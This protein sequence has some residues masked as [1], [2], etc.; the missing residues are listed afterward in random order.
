[1]IAGVLVGLAVAGAAGWLLGSWLVFAL[2]ALPLAGLGVMFGMLYRVYRQQRR[3]I[4]TPERVDAQ[5]DELMRAGQ[6][7]QASRVL[8]YAAHLAEE[9]AK[10]PRPD[11]D[12]LAALAARW[13]ALARTCIGHDVNRRFDAFRAWRDQRYFD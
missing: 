11:R 6:W 1:V 12:A 13:D 7:R 4:E 8:L 10:E 2:S 3:V 5:V 9:A